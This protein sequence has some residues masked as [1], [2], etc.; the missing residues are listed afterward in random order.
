MD[1]RIDPII[2]INPRTMKKGFYSLSGAKAFDGSPVTRIRE[3]LRHP[4]TQAPPDLTIIHRILGAYEKLERGIPFD[5]TDFVL[6]GHELEE[7]KKIP[8]DTLGRYLIY[9]YKYNK[10]PQLHIVD[11]YPPCLQ[12]EPSSICNYRCVMCYQVDP[13]FSRRQSGHMGFMSLSLFK[14][15]VDQVEGQ[16][17]AFTL[18]SRGEPLLN[19]DFAEMIRYS[20][21]KFIGYK[22]NT[23]AS[24][25]DESLSHSILS[26][27]PCGTVVFSA[28]AGTADMYEQIRVG[29]KFERVLKNIATFRKIKETRYPESRLITR[30]SGVKINARQDPEKMKSFWL[31]YVDQAGFINYSPWHRSYEAQPNDLSH[32][33]SDLWRRMFIWFDGTVNPCDYDYKSMLS[34]GNIRDTTVSDAWRSSGYDR[35]RQAHLTGNRGRYVPCNGCPMT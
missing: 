13:T 1:K 31:D 24:V 22:I 35:L 5:E 9:R 28:D 19:K 21:S 2:D 32:P 18:A 3:W 23:N 10:Y 26:H 6:S 12:V 30:V 25:L 4:G 20:G 17:E 34:V 27:I 16:I 14:E 29:G 8:R 15:I 7:V 11:A 33:C